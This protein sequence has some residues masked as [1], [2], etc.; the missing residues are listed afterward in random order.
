M[1]EERLGIILEGSSDPLQKALAAATKRFEQFE[2][3]VNRTVGAAQK[4]L[5]QYQRRSDSIFKAVGK[6]LESAQQAFKGLEK[7]AE[8]VASEFGKDSKE[9]KRVEKQMDLLSKAM[10]RAGTQAGKLGQDM[11]E[12]AQKATVATKRL[13]DQGINV[14]TKATKGQAAA[15]KQVASA[16]AKAT[17]ATKKGTA[18]SKKAGAA[19]RQRA[20]DVK[21]LVN[22]LG[23]ARKAALDFRTA[24]QFLAGAT[25]GAVVIKFASDFEKALANVETLL[26][27]SAVSIERYRSQLDALAKASPKEIIDL[28]QGLYQTISAGIPQVEGAAGAFAVL[29]QAQRAAVAGLS[30]TEQAVGAFTTILNAYKDTGITATEVSD[31][32]F[33]TVAKGRTVFPE[34]AGSIGRVA[35]VAS[36]AGVGI[37]ELLGATIS[38]TKAGLSTDEAVTQLRR[39]ILGLLKPSKDVQTQFQEL[40]VDFGE[41]ALRAKGLAGILAEVNQVT[42]GSADAFA[43]LFPNVRAMVGAVVLGAGGLDDFRQ[44]ISFVEKATGST[45]KAYKKISKTFDT[46]AKLL[47]SKLQA[48]LIN[49]GTKVFPRLIK[50]LE[51]TGEILEKNQGAITRI[52]GAFVD[53]SLAVGG[54]LA[55]HA[56]GL[57][58]F[59]G[60]L[61]TFFLG[62]KLKSFSLLFIKEMRKVRLAAL[63]AGQRAGDAFA[64]G[65]AT[66][67]AK[68][69]AAMAQIFRSPSLLASVAFFGALIV[70]TILDALNEAEARAAQRRTKRAERRSAA[71]KAKADAEAKK[72][73][74]GSAEEQK[75]ETRSALS[76]AGVIITGPKKEDIKRVNAEVKRLATLTAD[77]AAKALSAGLDASR[78]A[79]TLEVDALVAQAGRVESE[80]EALKRRAVRDPELEKETAD[81]AKALREQVALLR[82][83]Q[84]RREDRISTGVQL[85]RQ[86]K[87]RLEVLEERRLKQKALTEAHLDDVRALQ[88]AGKEE[89]ARAAKT[90]KDLKVARDAAAARLSEIQDQQ[91]ASARRLEDD[92]AKTRE[93]EKQDALRIKAGRRA[94]RLLDREQEATESLLAVERELLEEKARTEEAQLEFKLQNIRL[95]A[96]EEARGLENELLG[97]AEQRKELEVERAAVGAKAKKEGRAVTAAETALLEKQF[98]Q[99]ERIA[100]QQVRKQEALKDQRRTLAR[101]IASESRLARAGMTDVTN[102]VTLV[103]LRKELLEIDRERLD[104]SREMRDLFLQTELRATGRALERGE[105]IPGAGAEARGIAPDIPEELF[106]DRESIILV[107]D[108][109]D[110]FATATEKADAALFEAGIRATSFSEILGTLKEDSE[111]FTES[112]LG[113]QKAK[114]LAEGAGNI[115]QKA[116]AAPAGFLKS[117]LEGGGED[118]QTLEQFLEETFRDAGVPLKQALGLA[119]ETFGDRLTKQ[120]QKAFGIVPEAIDKGFG[121]TFRRRINTAFEDAVTKLVFGAIEAGEKFADAVVDGF[122]AAIDLFREAVIDPLEQAISTPLQTLLGSFGGAVEALLDPS[123]LGS[124]VEEERTARKKEHN[125]RIRDLIAEGAEATAISE[126]RAEFLAQEREITREQKKQ[127]AGAVLDR[128][129]NQAVEFAE[130]VLE[131][132]PGLLDKFFDLVIEK[133]PAIVQL[134]AQAISDVLDVI[135]DR[136]DELVGTLVQA[137]IDSLPVI[138]DAIARNLA[139]I[140]EAILNGILQIVDNLPEIVETL[141]DGFIKAFPR[142]TREIIAA[143]PKLITAFVRAIPLIAAKLLDAIGPITQGLT[144]SLFDLLAGLIEEAPNLLEDAISETVPAII[145]A[146]IAAIPGVAE[147]F[148]RAI[149]GGVPRLF[150][151]IGEL[152]PNIAAAIGRAFTGGNALQAVGEFISKAVEAILVGLPIAIANKLEKFFKNIVDAIL[153][154]FDPGISD[155]KKQAAIDLLFGGGNRVVDRLKKVR[156][157]P[158]RAGLAAATGGLSEFFLHKGGRIGGGRGNS[159]LASALSAAGAQG[160]ATG[161]LVLPDLGS[162]VR[163]TLQRDD[164]VATLQSGE[165]VLNRGAMGNIGGAGNL[166]RLNNGDDPQSVFGG[167]GS[168]EVTVTVPSTGIGAI[169]ALRQFIVSTIIVAMQSPGS[170]LRQA[171]ARGTV[172]GAKSVRGRN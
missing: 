106:E 42:G 47:K 164:V 64:S 74:F 18:A 56:K 99:E 20:K 23:K 89:Q 40:G 88:L 60:G 16:Q 52:T 73:G 147:G 114:S 121:E 154:A 50:A 102:N 87:A 46:T 27:S 142:V 61:T 92:L 133:A 111:A 39:L 41:T 1:A 163:S 43:K 32:L 2:K 115:L 116:F 80:L 14:V 157:D 123:L 130:K 128:T 120:V 3:G 169:D 146:S 156:E 84:V 45:D 8:K 58:I 137:F 17:K 98:K 152:L 100:S 166:G 5:E 81:E 13:A 65:F 126:E 96:A 110:D 94:E 109:M 139:P 113:P 4:R 9:Y 71:A 21:L 125:E 134:A 170:P 82:E 135:G 53:F 97:F 148:I 141:V 78:A 145:K 161:G 90:A 117:L 108:A 7:A 171:A 140:V 103:G 37:D 129:A 160:F 83:I 66:G 122:E 158:A 104:L 167:G 55:D 76:Q 127:S 165:G 63:F 151:A 77:G 159:G 155:E 57:L 101:T 168:G 31:K 68:V 131:V 136:I 33:K 69:K 54:F 25:A 49:A 172:P 124:V 144:D 28:T 10:V 48:V 24:L 79:L 112:L 29:E 26:D 118:G 72:L 85:A 38:L 70:G 44:S 15:L 105:G 138:V 67:A 119:T 107:G 153:Q 34:L 143:I 149:V 75:S 51:R 62:G 150:A 6:R 30:S 36:R 35:T 162:A 95:A 93:M 91:V 86:G 12:G 132:L 11:A 19:T 59:F 22:P